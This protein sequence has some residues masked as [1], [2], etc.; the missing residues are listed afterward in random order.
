VVLG[1]RVP[2]VLA[3]RSDSVESRVASLVLALLV[4]RSRHAA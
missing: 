3:N 2:I 4:A 1:G